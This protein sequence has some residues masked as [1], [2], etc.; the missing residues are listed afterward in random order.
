MSIKLSPSLSYSDMWTLKYNNFIIYVDD[1]SGERLWESYQQDSEGSTSQFSEDPF[2]KAAAMYRA[3]QYHGI[4]EA[5]SE[6]IDK[7]AST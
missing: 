6:A 7:G 2:V 5:L 3:K 4:I 1:L